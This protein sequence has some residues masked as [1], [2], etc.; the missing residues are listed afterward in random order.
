MQKIK[1]ILKIKG[2]GFQVPEKSSRKSKVILKI[3]GLQR[4]FQ[5]P[6][7]SSRTEVCKLQAQRQAQKRG[8]L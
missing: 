8:G 7:K 1:I 3:K 4:F 2:L 5:V 6:E